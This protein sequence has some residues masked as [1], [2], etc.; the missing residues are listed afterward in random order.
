MLGR[1][2]DGVRPRSGITA[3]DF[4]RLVDRWQDE[5]Y[6]KL[7]RTYDDEAYCQLVALKASNLVVRRYEYE[8]RR[9]LLVSRPYHLFVDPA[10]ACQLAC[11]GCVH[12]ANP[13][14]K[15]SFHWPNKTLKV[16]QYEAFLS[17]LGPFASFGMLYNYGEPLLSPHFPTLVR[18]AKSYLMYTMA[19][20][21]LSL[22]IDADAIVGSGLD[23]LII[24]IDGT[25]QDVYGRYRRRGKLDL[26]LDNVR[27]LVAAKKRA[28]SQTPYLCWQFLTFEHNAHQVEEAMQLARL[29]DVDC[30]SVFTPFE[31]TW[32]DPTIKAVRSPLR[33]SHDFRQHTAG[34]VAPTKW[35]SE[36]MKTRVVPH[37]SAA[38]GASWIQRFRD[39]GGLDEPEHPTGY[40]CPY[41]YDAIT[42]DGAGRVLPCCMAPSEAF[43]GLVF[44]RINADGPR[45][46]LVNSPMALLARTA[47][48]NR[49]QFESQSGGRSPDEVPYC[50]TC[51]QGPKGPYHLESVRRNFRSLDSEHVLSDSYL[52]NFT[53]GEPG[54]AA[55][56]AH[57]DAQLRVAHQDP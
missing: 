41:L 49:A 28:G 55:Y 7:L 26:V 14:Y 56:W 12:T 17:G 4:L 32:D 11:P 40:S 23:W 10:N 43:R 51:T 38:F 57:Y 50:A 29:L 19:S 46:D 18:L 54:A 8:R 44:G 13:A 5:V 31:V 52:D 20:T 53:A 9:S 45:I 36:E 22:P 35:C 24:S 1:L 15:S 42:L 30:L 3:V 48:T 47:F 21:N 37:V 6:G 39:A 27:K 34:R 2:Q 33:G 25:T 16:D